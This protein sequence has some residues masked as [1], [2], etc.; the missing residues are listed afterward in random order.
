MNGQTPSETLHWFIQAGKLLFGRGLVSSHSGNL[1]QRWKDKLYITRTGSSLPLFSEIDLI[2]T[3]LDH[4]DQFTPLASSEL[5]VHRAIYRRTSAKAIVHAHP[6]YAAA[7]SLL[8]GEIIP[9]CGEGLYCL[10]TIPVIGFGERVHPGSLAEEVATA[11]ETHRVIV[12]AGHGS[13]ATG[14]NIEEAL[15]YTFALEEMCQV[16]YL[17]RILKKAD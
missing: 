14:E 9:D 8:E 1:S 4:N 3:G 15:K 6:P 16:T 17:A 10:G 13:F 7:L 5:P 11:L 12:V 2:L